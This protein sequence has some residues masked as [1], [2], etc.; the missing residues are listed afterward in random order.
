MGEVCLEKT[1]YR[2]DHQTSEP[3]PLILPV[4]AIFKS[5]ISIHHP[6]E[7]SEPLFLCR[8]EKVS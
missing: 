8:E 3:S 6:L 4:V 2:F 7:L 5:R 1:Y